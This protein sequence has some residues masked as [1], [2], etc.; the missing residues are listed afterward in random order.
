MQAYTIA[1]RLQ[2]I[3]A[4]KIKQGLLQPG[5]KIKSEI[6]LASE[7]NVSR[8]TVRRALANL[9]Q[10]NLIETRIGSGSYVA[11][12]GK[13][14][15]NA[16]S[17]TAESVRSGTPTTTELLSIKRINCPE[18]LIA[19]TSTSQCYE[20][21]RRRLYHS[22]PVSYEISLLPETKTLED[23]I[24]K[25][26]GLLN[27]SL[28]QTMQAAKLIT[29]HGYTDISVERLN[30]VAKILER[31]NSTVFLLSKHHSYSQSGELVEYVTSY[32]DPSHFTLHLSSGAT[33]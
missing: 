3:I 26:N 14:F 15:T 27:N 31:Q 10:A 22:T 12:H 7:Y 1:E 28:S 4:S 20:I 33:I 23:V 8:G 29:H 24:C 32:L 13:D 30:S 19:E 11:F 9:Q 2:E 16:K 25:N 17:W 5:E 21:K 6:Q 18:N